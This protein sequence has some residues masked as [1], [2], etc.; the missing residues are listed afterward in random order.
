[1]LVQE[2]RPTP[3]MIDRAWDSNGDGGGVAWRENGFVMFR[4]GIM[5]R[6]DFA[7]LLAKTPMP[8]VA[9][10]R[11]A[12]VGG[13]Q[14]ELTHPFPIELTAPITLVG[15]TKGYVLFHNG[16]WGSWNEKAME[17]AIRSNKPVPF[18]DWSDTR[19]MAWLCSIYGH[20]FLNFLPSQKGILFGPKDMDILTG[21]GWTEI[22][23]VWCS[24]DYFIKKKSYS[25]HTPTRF[26]TVGQCM[27]HCMPGKETCAVHEPTS[28]N[29]GTLT[30]GQTHSGNG[31]TRASGGSSNVSPFPL[32]AL[33][34]VAHAQ[35]LHRQNLLSK[36]A[37]KKIKRDHQWLEAG[38]KKAER[39]KKS[40]EM[41]TQVI[42]SVLSGG[43]V[44]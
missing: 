11:V 17:A 7:E 13:V 3:E 26:C 2:A 19:A 42:V 34:T 16:H 32:G 24:N 18:G 21:D 27:N 39:A 33:V 5:N 9:H 30:A 10:F 28:N 35:M 1:M 29:G 31:N 4:K 15:K 14:K 25:N 23:K 40:L 36:S 6:K 43:Q 8:Y 44:H 38:G 22:N 41:H 12:S 37:L 20:G